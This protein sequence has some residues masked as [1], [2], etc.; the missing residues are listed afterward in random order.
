MGSAY[1]KQRSVAR[2]IGLRS[3]PACACTA[4]IAAGVRLP[5]VQRILGHSG[6]G[7]TMRY[8]HVADPERRAAIARHPINGWLAEAA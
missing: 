3:A 7:T 2:Y 1:R 4:L 8:L 6:I 5:E